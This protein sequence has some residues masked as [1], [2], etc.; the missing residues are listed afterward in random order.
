MQDYPVK[1]GSMLFTMV[2][3]NVGFEVAY[4]NWY[5]RDHFYGGCMIGPWILAGSRWV[6]P[7]TLKDLR[8]PAVSPFAEPI[9]AGSYVAIYFVHDGHVKDHFDWA[10]KQ[11]VELYKDGRG[12]QERSHAH[13]CLYDFA[14]AVYAEGETVS[15]EL[16]LDHRYK[17]LVTIVTEPTQ[18]TTDEEHLAAVQG[19]LAGTLFEDQAVRIVSSWRLRGAGVQGEGAPMKLGTDGGSQRRLVNLVFVDG[20]EGTTWETVTRAAA[21]LN[22]AGKASVTFASPWYPTNIGTNDYTDQLW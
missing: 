2:D 20:V 5:E 7:R 10:G 1:V 11:V 22:A 15:I 21:A 16:A 6:S 12:F 4:N 9:H 3:P 18:G 17:G 13:T 14:D 8:F 19:T